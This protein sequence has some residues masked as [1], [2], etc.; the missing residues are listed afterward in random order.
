MKKGRE[1]HRQS[2]WDT[3]PDIPTLS[4]PLEPGDLYVTKNWASGISL[5]YQHAGLISDVTPPRI[6]EIDCDRTGCRIK[7][8]KNE[9]GKEI[10][11]ARL[12]SDIPD[13]AELI[14]EAIAISKYLIRHHKVTYL[15]LAHFQIGQLLRILMGR[16]MGKVGWTELLTYVRRFLTPYIEQTDYD[17]HTYAIFC[18]R[19]SMI[20]YQLAAWYVWGKTKSPTEMSQ[21]L[22]RYFAFRP[23]YCRPWHIVML[24]KAN[25]PWM[26]FRTHQVIS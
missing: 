23:K 24:A 2:I 10:F 13:R 17:K 7:E 26:V 18:N 14:R 16:C 20:I 11:I 15:D 12:P 6:E 21:L 9:K 3:L 4:I 1:L 5:T 19:F 8:F 25:P 22:N